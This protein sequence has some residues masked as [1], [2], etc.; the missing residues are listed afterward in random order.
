MVT[1]KNIQIYPNPGSGNFTIDLAQSANQKI[2]VTIYNC[3]GQTIDTKVNKSSSKIN[4]D[5]SSVEDGIYFIEIKGD[6]KTLLAKKIVIH[7]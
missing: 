5:L 7:K 2:D 4:I 3:L 1:Q 6:D